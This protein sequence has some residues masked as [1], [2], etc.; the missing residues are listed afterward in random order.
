MDGVGS[1]CEDLADGN[2]VALGA[3]AAWYVLVKEGGC[4]GMH[5]C[6]REDGAL[7]VDQG[8]G[9]GLAQHAWGLASF[10]NVAD[11]SLQRH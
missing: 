2:G 3:A 4:E 11:A 7:T 6:M 10:R 8:G 5:G 1:F 9:Q